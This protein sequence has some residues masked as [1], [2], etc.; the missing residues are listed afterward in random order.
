MI[1]SKARDRF[2]LIY[3]KVEVLLVFQGNS[4]LENQK[5]LNKSWRPTSE[6]TNCS[7]W[8][9]S[10]FTSLAASKVEE[11]VQGWHKRPVSG[12][13]DR[14]PRDAGRCQ[15]GAVVSL[16]PE[17]WS[18]KRWTGKGGRP[19]C[20]GV[21]GRPFSRKPAALPVLRLMAFTGLRIPPGQ[22]KTNSTV[23]SNRS[24]LPD[25][26]GPVFGIWPWHKAKR[27][28][29]SRGYTYNRLFTFLS[30]LTRRKKSHDLHILSFHS[31]L[32]SW[33]RIFFKF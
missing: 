15:M 8:L 22:V 3:V 28:A 2:G 9:H 32:F 13:R 7:C 31:F 20:P 27:A 1:A 25:T 33:I 19:T 17:A 12:R 16:F 18:W 30:F 29:N 23:L 6:V 26:P 5:Q 21:Q 14:Q 11:R 24:S 10:C 4:C